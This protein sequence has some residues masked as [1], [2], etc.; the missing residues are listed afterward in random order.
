MA[1]ILRYFTEFGSFRGPLRQS[2]LRYTYT[3]CDG[4]NIVL[5]LK[6]VALNVN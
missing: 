4:T 6:V 3:F 2:G 1:V 5:G